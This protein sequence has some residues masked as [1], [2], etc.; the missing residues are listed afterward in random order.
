MR[1]RQHV[2][3]LACARACAR[4]CM[5]RRR[6]GGGARALHKER[7]LRLDAALEELPVQPHALDLVQAVGLELVLAVAA[8]LR[9][10]W[11]RH[12]KVLAGAE[13]AVELLLGTHGA[14]LVVRL[15]RNARSLLA[16]LL[17]AGDVV[18]GGGGV[19]EAVL[20]AAG[21]RRHGLLPPLRLRGGGGRAHHGR[22]GWQ[23]RVGA[24]GARRR[25][26]GGRDGRQVRVGAAGARCRAR[27]VGRVGAARAREG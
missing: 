10:G 4:A 27:D 20:L 12:L 26:R 5:Y 17:V 9:L 6:A 8:V 14:L 21:E 13:D 19:H 11:R 7:Q 3:A 18:H 24:A 23:V 1:P 16:L 15:V 22:H 25:R 2:P